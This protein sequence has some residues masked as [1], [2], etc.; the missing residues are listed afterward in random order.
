MSKNSKEM[1]LK[2]YNYLKDKGINVKWG[3]GNF[4]GTPK[5][6]ITINGKEF[7]NAGTSYDYFSRTQLD[8]LLGLLEMK[9][10]RTKSKEGYKISP[11]RDQLRVK[12][13]KGYIEGFR[14]K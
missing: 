13:Q 8:P 1:T 5:Y 6:H 2:I 12:I 3:E 10:Y 14:E 7:I 9:S 4:H 11:L